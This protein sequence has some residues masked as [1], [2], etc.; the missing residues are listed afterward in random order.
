M[1]AAELTLYSGGTS[2]AEAEF[3]R[4]A[5]QH[6]IQEINYAFEGHNNARLRGLHELSRE[7]LVQGDVSLHYVSNLLNRNYTQKGDTFRKVL[8]VLFHIVNNS[9]EVFVIGEIQDDLTVKGGTGWGTEF[10]KICNKTLHTFDQKQDA[11]FRWADNQWNKVDQ[12][13]ISQPHFAGIGTR[14]LKENGIS[15]IAGVYAKTLG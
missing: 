7:E 9:R 1:N 11:W 6:G 3:G 15:A 8:Q 4:M 10:A 13:V 12:P 2:G 5:E 14:Y